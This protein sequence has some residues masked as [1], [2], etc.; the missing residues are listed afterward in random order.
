MSG[1][2]WRLERLLHEFHRRGLVA[3]GCDEAA[4]FKPV[5]TVIAFLIFELL[6]V[7]IQWPF[8]ATRWLAPP[9]PSLQI[10]P[11]ELKALQSR[12]GSPTPVLDRND[13]WMDDTEIL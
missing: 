7:S 4:A 5:V 2:P 8:S 1:L 11:A 12:S 13:I 3:P 10:S 6:I 9:D